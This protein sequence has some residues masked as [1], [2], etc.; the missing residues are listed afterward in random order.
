MAIFAKERL[1]AAR[2]AGGFF[3]S[4]DVADAAGLSRGAYLR[5][6]SGLSGLKESHVPALSRVI[7]VSEEFLRD[8]KV[9][10]RVDHLAHRLV[11]IFLSPEGDMDGLPIAS[12]GRLKEMRIAGGFNSIKAASEATGWSF[13]SLAAHEAGTRPLSSEKM[14]GYALSLG[15]RP[16]YA[17]LGTGGRDPSGGDVVDWWRNSRVEVASDL[18][19]S[20]VWSWL[21]KAKNKAR[22]SFPLIALEAGKAV[23][24]DAELVSLPHSLLP[25]GD[26]RALYG[27][28]EKVSGLVRVSIVEP[29]QA[30]GSIARF[31]GD[32]LERAKQKIVGYEPVDPLK[33]SKLPKGF[34]FGTLV[35]TLD[36]HS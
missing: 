18:L 27:I 5:V 13:T 33:Q 15:F 6:E 26:D 29:G 7:G 23:R 21:N 1:K 36:I 34:C 35:A 17:I 16:E 8:G 9:A 31:S 25:S 22:Q 10:N 3:V 12:V 19:S 14:A 4:S 2:I 20:P 11:D 24:F 32:G 28:V 30:T